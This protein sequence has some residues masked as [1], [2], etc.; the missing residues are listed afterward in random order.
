MP[1][2]ALTAI[3]D[4]TNDKCFLNRIIMSE[5][6]EEEEEHSDDE[7]REYLVFMYHII[8]PVLLIDFTNARNVAR[9]Y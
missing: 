4:P 8:R 7:D 1:S 6:E 5:E 2:L 3:D 9:Y